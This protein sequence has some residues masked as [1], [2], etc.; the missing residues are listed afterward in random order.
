[1]NNYELMQY[2]LN[3]IKQFA[4][5]NPDKNIN[6]NMIYYCLMTYNIPPPQNPTENITDKFPLLYDYF[7]NI[8]NIHL[9]EVPNFNFLIFKNK[10]LNGN[11][12]KLYAPYDS[13]HIIEAAKKIFGFMAYNNIAHQSK[14]AYMIRNDDLVIRVNTLSDAEKIINFIKNDPFLREN[15]LNVNPFLPNNSG[16]GMA[17]DNNLSFNS[18]LCNI[19]SNYVSLLRK[20]NRINDLNVENLNAYIK[21]CIPTIQNLDEKDIYKLLEKTTSKNFTINDFYEHANNKQKYIYD[22]NRRRINIDPSYLESAIKI[23]EQY[24]PGYTISAITNY[25]N[26]GIATGFTR[27]ENARSNLIANIPPQMVMYIINSYLTSK[28]IPYSY[29]NDAIYKY[30]NNILNLEKNNNNNDELNLDLNTIIEMII[31]AYINTKS[32]YGKRQANWAL[33]SLLLNGNLNYFT[34]QFNDR[35]NLKNLSN[36]YNLRQCIIMYLGKNYEQATAEEI[37][38]RMEDMM[39]E[40]TL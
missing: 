39:A 30:V 29:T 2:F 14:I 11:E 32:K 18:V 27:K 20:E 40:K 25:I 34:N 26:N 3:F 24:H 28:N 12:I 13:K 16:I 17:M 37:V 35:T 4:I 36:K 10:N 23:T 6:K 15:L 9:Y 7:K 1:M 22:S 19:I 33:Q 8:H 38:L 21:K 31:N 5:E